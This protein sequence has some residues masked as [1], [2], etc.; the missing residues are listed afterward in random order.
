MRVIAK[1]ALRQFW[2]RYPDAEQQ[3]R[4]WYSEAKS[5][6]WRTPADVK[7]KHR[8]ASILKAGRVIFNLCGNKYRLVVRINYAYQIVYVRFIGSH[9][10]YD[11]IDVEEV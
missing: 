1:R 10:E 3:L 5:A 9:A 2:Q 11:E 7:A 6:D 8:S 4:A